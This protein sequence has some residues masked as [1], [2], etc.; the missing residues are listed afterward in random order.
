M[1]TSW[2][3][4]PSDPAA[5]GAELE[6]D[7]DNGIEL[8]EMDEYNQMVGEEDLKEQMQEGVG[9]A[10]REAGGFDYRGAQ[11]YPD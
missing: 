6:V 4:L 11:Y 8:N 2:D 9:D 10:D 7:A 3:T 1:S 5:A